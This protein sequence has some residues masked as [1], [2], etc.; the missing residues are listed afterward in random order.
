M[1]KHKKEITRSKEELEIAWAEYL[2]RK[3][4]KRT[5]KPDAILS[6]QFQIEGEFVDGPAVGL[7]IPKKRLASSY[8]A[9][10]RG[11]HLAKV[12]AFMEK[13]VRQGY[14][15]KLSVIKSKPAMDWEEDD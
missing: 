7:W 8:Y 4:H 9:Y 14:D 1:K 12:S 2:E 11:D 5:K 3:R 15:I 6:I 13:A 10:V